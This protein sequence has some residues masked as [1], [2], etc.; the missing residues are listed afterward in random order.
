MCVLVVKLLAIVNSTITPYFKQPKILSRNGETNSR[1][2]YIGLDD[3]T[4]YT[5]FNIIM[6]D[7]KKE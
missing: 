5:K 6:Y 7:K 1:K 3:T 2:L 4:L